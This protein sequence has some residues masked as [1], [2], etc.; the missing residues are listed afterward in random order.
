M[1]RPCFDCGL[2]KTAIKYIFF[3]I[4]R[5]LNMIAIRGY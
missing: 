5:D 1:I 3:T 4:V 2:D